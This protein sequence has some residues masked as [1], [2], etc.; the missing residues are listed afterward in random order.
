[1]DGSSPEKTKTIG[2]KRHPANLKYFSIMIT[3]DLLNLVL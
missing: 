2:Q 3:S 1:M